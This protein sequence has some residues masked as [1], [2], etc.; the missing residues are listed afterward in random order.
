MHDLFESLQ[1]EQ[2]KQQLC[3]LVEPEVVANLESF[4][5][6][7]IESGKTI[8]PDKKYWFR[9]L[10]SVPIESVKVVILGQDPYHGPNQAHGFSFS[11]PDGLKLPPSLKNIFKEQQSDLDIANTSGNL[12]QWAQQ[13]VLMINAVLTVE[14]SKAGSHSKKGWEEITDAVIQICNNQ[15]EPI[16]FLLWGSYAIKKQILITNK[17][18]LVLTAVHPSPLSAHRGWFGCKH[19]SKANQYLIESSRSPIDWQINSPEQKTFSF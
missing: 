4:L 17:R 16:V 14:H 7:E 12:T 18:H 19:F 2:W 13:G 9:A 15:N 11:V 8:Y 1:D 6:S 10:N 5:C 3:N